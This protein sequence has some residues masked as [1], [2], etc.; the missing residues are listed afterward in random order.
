M[1]KLGL[2][3]FFVSQ[4]LL[5]LAVPSGAEASFRGMTCGLRFET[6]KESVQM[7]RACCGLGK[8]VE[9]VIE[10]RLDYLNDLTGIPNTIP[11]AKRKAAIDKITAAPD[12]S[13]QSQIAYE[14]YWEN[15][16]MGEDRAAVDLIEIRE[17]NLTPSSFH[18]K[19]EIRGTVDHSIAT[20]RI[21]GGPRY[22]NYTPSYETWKEVRFDAKGGVFSKVKIPH[23]IQFRFFDEDLLVKTRYEI[24]EFILY[25][26][27]LNS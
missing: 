22:E 13:W 6:H 25:C 1:S 20:L 15:A 11:A 12:G 9:K 7:S 16:F 14:T 5:S 17:R 24:P 2:V 27:P 21:A 18:I 26:L 8:K 4:I 19:L 3:S 23:P 10:S